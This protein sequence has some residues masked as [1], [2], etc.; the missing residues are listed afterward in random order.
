VPYTINGIGTHYYGHRNASAVNGTCPQCQ[1]PAKLSSYD[2]TEFFCILFIPLIPIKK[3]RIENEC[4]RCRRHYR[5]ALDKFNAAIDTNIT[6]LRDAVKRDPGDPDKREAL[7][8]ALMGAKLTAD[9]ENEARDAATKFGQSYMLNAL[10]GDLASSRSDATTAEAW[11]RRAVAADPKSG[12]AHVALGQALLQLKRDDEAMRALQTGIMFEPASVSGLYALAGVQMRREQW[13]DAFTTLQRLTNAKPSLAQDR[14]VLRMIGDCKKKLGYALTPVEQKASRRWWPRRNAKTPTPVGTGSAWSPTSSAVSLK[15]IGIALAC[16]VVAAVVIGGTLGWWRQTHVA[17]YFDNALGRTLTYNVDGETFSLGARPPLLHEMKPG[18]HRIVVLDHGKELEHLGPTIAEQ[19]LLSALFSP[20]FYVY[21]TAG[22]GIYRAGDL[23]YAVDESERTASDEIVAFD[24]WLEHDDVDYTFTDPP[25]EVSVDSSSRKTRK[26]VF[27][28]ADRV[29]YR[30]LALHRYSEGKT[31]EALRAMKK[32]TELAPCDTASRRDV[33][34]IL[35][36]SA[37]LDGAIAEGRAWVAS[38]ADSI[39]AHRGYQNA[40]RAAGHDDVVLNEYQQRLAEH[41]S[42]LNHYLYGRLLVGQPAIAEQREAL[43]LDPEL[44]WAHIALGYEMLQTENDRAAVAEFSDA[45]AHK[46]VDPAVAMYLAMAAIGAHAEDDAL[47]RLEAAKHLAGKT[48]DARFLLAR[49]KRDYGT[50]RTMLVARAKAEP[51]S[52]VVAIRRADLDL[53][54]GA[55]PNDVVARL[56]TSPDTKLYANAVA[57]HYAVIEGRAGDAAAIEQRELRSDKHPTLLT[58][59]AAET[60][61]LAH[62]PGAKEQVAAVE[63]AFPDGGDTA[64][65]FS[66][67]LTRALSGNATE[68]EMLAAARKLDPEMTPHAWY[69][70]GVQAATRGDRAHA[71]AYFRKAADRSLMRQFPYEA[72]L[73]HAKEYGG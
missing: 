70:L 42:A 39:D 50:A 2:T 62:A 73:R 19:P 25:N 71:A 22:A 67:I 72:A 60:A 51:K 9:A 26:T 5:V 36:Q 31:D 55:A 16:V 20:H 58:I 57:F 47:A 35:E 33:L 46:D 38:C 7:I 48:W 37:Q 56:S 24:R 30:A 18:A 8:R 12:R 11:Y 66:H 29:T 49:A 41:P 3:Y 65:H 44:T 64:A 14:A 45:L 68:A 15:G 6:P 17:V 27:T 69:A 40:Q 1:K 53:D 34:T 59:Y 13:S 4:S 63:A 54:T 32:A 21:N 61:L 23:V 43:R 52:P 10:A 28:V